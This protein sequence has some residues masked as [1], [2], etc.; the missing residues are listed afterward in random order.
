MRPSPALPLG[1]SNGATPPSFR[2][3]LQI[4][5]RARAY[6]EQLHVDVWDFAVEI[7]VL[8]AA[9]IDNSDLRLLTCQGYIDHAEERT[10]LAK[11]R[12]TFARAGPL[13]LSSHTCFVLTAQGLAQLAANPPVPAS[14]PENNHATPHWDAQLREL[15]LAGQLVKRYRVPA[16]NQELILSA[17]EEE[18]WPNHIDDPLPPLRDVCP[19]RRLNDAIWCLNRNQNRRLIRFA[20]NGNGRG[21]RWGRVS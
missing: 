2:L 3:A 7:D 17:F 20:G 14:L 12:R 11:E 16:P 18:G 8:R 10:P 5:A 9:G 13:I 4:L 6:A 1:P 19:K 15:R 21:L